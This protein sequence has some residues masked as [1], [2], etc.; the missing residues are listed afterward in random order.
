M[1]AEKMTY[2]RDPTAVLDEYEIR[3]L[4]E[5]LEFMGDGPGLDKILRLEWQERTTIESPPPPLLLRLFRQPRPASER[6]QTHLAWFEAKNRS[7]GAVDFFADVHRAWRLAAQAATTALA[8]GQL[9]TE[10]GLEAR[11]ALLLASVNSYASAVPIP[12]VVALVR[13]EVWLPTQA[14]AYARRL[15]EPRDRSAAFTALLPML[16]EPLCSEITAEAFTTA[17][18]VAGAR[19]PDPVVVDNDVVLERETASRLAALLPESL[20]RQAL[21]LKWG[22]RNELLRR[23][24]ELGH[25]DDAVRL[26]GQDLRCRADLIPYMSEERVRLWLVELP[27][28]Q[29][30]AMVLYTRL[31]ALGYPDE[32]MHFAP[33]IENIHLR[34]EFLNSIAGYLPTSMLAQAWAIASQ[35]AEPDAQVKLLAAL[36][37][38]APKADRTRFLDDALALLSR[39]SRYSAPDLLA[40]L[41]PLCDERQLD[42]AST[43]LR[44]ARG[45][46]FEGRL[47]SFMAIACASQG[48]RRDK[49]LK[50]A[51]AL[52]AK[53]GRQFS[54]R[55]YCRWLLAAGWARADPYGALQASISADY[56][57]EGIEQLAPYLPRDLLP[58]ALS[59]AGRVRDVEWRKARLLRQI[60][61]AAAILMPARVLPVLVG[62]S[63]MERAAGISD[64][65]STLPDGDLSAAVDIVSGIRASEYRVPALK[66]LV[67]RLPESLVDGILERCREDPGR[68]VQELEIFAP[69]LTAGKLS[70]AFTTANGLEDPVWRAKAHR[71]LAAHLP[72]PELW[73]LEHRVR[74]VNGLSADE[75]RQVLAELAVGFASCGEHRHAVD[76]L[77]DIIP[78]RIDTAVRMAASLPPDM[79]GAAIDA[80]GSEGMDPVL[81]PLAQRLD[82]PRRKAW[83]EGAMLSSARPGEVDAFR[84]E[85][86]NLAR[87]A[88]SFGEPTVASVLDM[89]VARSIPEAIV[90]LAPALPSDL[91]GRA[92]ELAR[93]M[94][95]NTAFNEEAYRSRTF[96]ALADRAGGE[97]AE[98]LFEEALESAF[99]A[100]PTRDPVTDFAQEADLWRDIRARLR[101]MPVRRQHSALRK[102]LV[103]LSERDH[104]D[105]L[106]S[107]GELLPLIGNLGGDKA[108]QEVMRAASDVTRWWA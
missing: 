8:T 50:A 45:G 62:M 108:L 6:V 101:A 107:L 106:A 96:L 51:L 7:N 58:V 75:E 34:L 74:A 53:G 86:N 99:D 39:V 43:V 64:L 46:S 82:P 69:Y 103:K 30:P 70:E 56:L 33:T 79:V 72:P 97:E 23:L 9:V 28:G 63:E 92:A 40:K 19:D 12:L 94:K 24:A 21:A 5:H 100:T 68:W 47:G 13:G 55:D 18:Q 15:P 49:A 17:L 11:Y 32:A 104:E 38:G 93:S 71:S 48:P 85:I 35:L 52:P 10:L 76:L 98:M 2:D 29:W 90:I 25:V 42:Q 37:A 26:T 36:A 22:P 81:A 57:E 27:V 66:A 31:A 102:A 95:W 65:A 91:V 73:E 14:V 78:P 89:V 20:V 83:L 54:A 77:A 80:L 61:A 87:L 3:H 60:T 59:S 44:S 84:A 1:P 67:P 41:I 4:T 88:A 105:C 16:P